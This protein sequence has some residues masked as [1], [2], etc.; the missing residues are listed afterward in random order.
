MTR[1]NKCRVARPSLR[2]TT[3]ERLAHVVGGAGVARDP[4]AV[5][6]LHHQLPVATGRLNFYG[7]LEFRRVRTGRRLDALEFGNYPVHVGQYYD[8]VRPL[9]PNRNHCAAPQATTFQNDPPL[10]PDFEKV[11]SA[12]Y[13]RSP[14]DVWLLAYVVA[15]LLR[16]ASRDRRGDIPL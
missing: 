14:I 2:P 10:A 9:L 4:K 15:Q 16:R 7:G 5:R 13:R 6:G 12:R 8:P 11:I 3:N 1:C